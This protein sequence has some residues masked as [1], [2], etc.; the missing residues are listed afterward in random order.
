MKEKNKEFDKA[1]VSAKKKNKEEK[2][3]AA[4]QARCQRCY[5]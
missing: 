1:I 4:S 3:M 5:F 2:K